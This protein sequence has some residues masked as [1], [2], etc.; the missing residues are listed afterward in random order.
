MILQ[1]ILAAVA[2]IAVTA[3]L[4]WHRV[5]VL[6]KIRK[7]SSMSTR[8]SAEDGNPSSESHDGV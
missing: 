3:K 7:P 1:G 4:W 2:A 6:L 5:L 8:G